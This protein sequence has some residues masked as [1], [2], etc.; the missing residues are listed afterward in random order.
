M[1]WPSLLSPTEKQEW[2]FP[3]PLSYR[4]AFRPDQRKQQKG[5]KREREPLQFCKNSLKNR[6]AAVCFVISTVVTTVQLKQYPPSITWPPG[7][8]LLVA[9]AVQSM[10]W[11]SLHREDDAS[12]EAAATAKIHPVISKAR[13]T[14]PGFHADGNVC[15]QRLNNKCT[16]PS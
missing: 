11:L 16:K 9:K 13:K 7:I 6:S 10:A 15:P 8:H 12:P 14:C 5:R 1:L 4:F 2:V 3:M